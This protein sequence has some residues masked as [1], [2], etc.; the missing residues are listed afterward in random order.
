MTTSGGINNDISKLLQAIEDVQASEWY[1]SGDV[2]W[3]QEQIDMWT[4]KLSELKRLQRAVEWLQ[5]REM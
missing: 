1:A 3:I 4:Q 2:D 5:V